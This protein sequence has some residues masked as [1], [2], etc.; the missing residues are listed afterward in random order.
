MV[1]EI[2]VATSSDALEHMTA[3]SCGRGAAA[4]AASGTMGQQA[5]YMAVSKELLALAACST[6][7]KARRR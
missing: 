2:G 4:A 5:L 7:L 1:S 3:V 6:H